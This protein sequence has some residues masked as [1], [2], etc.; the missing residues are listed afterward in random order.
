MSL[1]GQD[2]P[3]QSGVDFTAEGKAGAVRRYPASSVATYEYGTTMTTD[4]V[5]IYGGMVVLDTD[6]GVR[7]PD[8]GDAVASMLGFTVYQNTGI[9]ED[10]GYKKGGLQYNVAV[11]EFGQILL[12]V[13]AGETLA[14]GD[15]L[16]LNITAGADFNTISKV[17]ADATHLAI[18]DKVRVASPSSN[19]LVLCNVIKY[20]N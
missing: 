9:V 15:T 20:A 18:S 4:E 12:P 16:T 6:G 10:A 19:G 5:I 13:S 14:V 1:K 11:C 7:N 3:L 8:T 17:S 2:T